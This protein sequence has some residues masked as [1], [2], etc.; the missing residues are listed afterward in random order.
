MF[1]TLTTKQI[2]TE[3][4]KKQTLTLSERFILGFQALVT[5]TK[6]SAFPG[7]A[8]VL[9]E[10]FNIEGPHT[11]TAHFSRPRDNLD[12]HGL[13]HVPPNPCWVL[14][15][16]EVQTTC[17]LSLLALLSTLPSSC[18]LPPTPKVTWSPRPGLLLSQ[19]LLVLEKERKKG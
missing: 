8:L 17:F 7:A 16:G 4:L 18:L 13:L 6:K 11:F 2:G 12:K 1:K 15:C 5:I 9:W 19:I 3:C 10:G 14:H